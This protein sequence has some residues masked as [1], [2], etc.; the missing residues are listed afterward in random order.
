MR[1]GAV[2]VAVVGAAWPPVRC[3]VGDYTARL[4]DALEAAGVSVARFGGAP[5]TW[6]TAQA[7]KL[8]A[9]LAAMSPDIV[10]VQYPSVGYGRSLAPSAL[11]LLLRPVPVV[12][13][14]HEYSIFRAYRWPWFAPFAYTA[15]ACVFT[16]NAE[17][18][19]FTARMPGMRAVSTVIPIGSNI[20]RGRAT[21]RDARAVCYFGL[22]MPG[23]GIEEFF[24]LAARLRAA[25]AAWK[26][27]LVGAVA[28]G[29]DAYAAGV[30]TQAEALGV[31][32]L[33]GLQAAAVADILQGI[34][35]AY[36]P[37][38]GGITERRGAVLA[39]LE[40]GVRV[41]GPLGPG[42]PDWLRGL[43]MDTATPQAACAALQ[44]AAAAPAAPAGGAAT[45]TS[46]PAIAARHIALYR[47]LVRSGALR[48]GQAA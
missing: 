3:G 1:R 41:L 8:A 7:Q 13:T 34:E 18:A 48:L 44:A 5:R 19:A 17:Q 26:L 20:P 33:L 14:L 2:K 9:A 32:T 23:K 40:N 30:V 11:P 27:L 38:P 46:W 29:C 35:Y 6:G 24:D 28:P 10:H 39:A 4:A 37:G 36:L 47:S 16:S 42:A 22:L 45:E 21:A 15:R 12:V 31:R 43:V 25:D